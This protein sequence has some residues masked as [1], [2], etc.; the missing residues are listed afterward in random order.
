VLATDAETTRERRLTPLLLCLSGEEREAAALAGEEEEEGETAAAATAN[1][2][3]REAATTPALV[4][5]PF[6][7][8]ATGLRME[9]TEEDSIGKGRRGRKQPI[10]KGRGKRSS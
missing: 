9:R 3:R 7:G 2:R 4:T 10:R 6:A 8:Q 1:V 5:L